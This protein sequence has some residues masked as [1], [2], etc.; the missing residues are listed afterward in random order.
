MQPVRTSMF[1]SVPKLPKA[2]LPPSGVDKNIQT[3]I[4]RQLIATLVREPKAISDIQLNPIDFTQSDMGDAYY[5]LVEMAEKNTAAIDFLTVAATLNADGKKAAGVSV[6][7][8]EELPTDAAKVSTYADSIIMAS[9]DRQVVVAASLMS[10]DPRNENYA[11]DLQRALEIGVGA[12]VVLTS[13]NAVDEFEEYLNHQEDG[14]EAPLSTGLADLDRHLAGGLH[15]GQVIVLAARPGE[16]KSAL[17]QGIAEHVA[18]GHSGKVAL[19]ISLEMSTNE[20]MQRRI[21]YASRGAVSLMSLRSGKYSNVER[22]EIKRILPTLRETKMEFL[23]SSAENIDGIVTTVRARN[24]RGDIGLVVLDYL[25]LIECEGSTDNREQQVAKVS[26]RVK[27]L[28]QYIKAPILLLSQL[29]RDSEKGKEKREPR[30]NDLRE[31]GSIE[32]DADVV[33]FIHDPTPFELRGRKPVQQKSIII[34]KQRAGAKDISVPVAWIGSQCRFGNIDSPANEPLAMPTEKSQ[35][36]PLKPATE[37]CGTTSE[38]K[39]EKSK[40]LIAAI[41]GKVEGIQPDVLE[42]VE[43]SKSAARARNTAAAAA[44]PFAKFVRRK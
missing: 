2:S 9:K 23:A 24:K 10:K 11:T 44:S 3:D 30:L 32:Q 38:R 6:R 29:N 14:S 15:A 40:Q 43:Q 39:L 4:E 16:G 12:K 7:A 31:S 25:Q 37:Y 20:I 34:A 35:P 27:Q 1:K 17:S 33:L 36:A 21:A 26:R 19:F 28:A 8:L 42:Q 13:S 22:A 41:D 18:S 5:V